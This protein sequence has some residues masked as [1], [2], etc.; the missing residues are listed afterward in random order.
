[1]MQVLVFDTHSATSMY[2][3]YSYIRKTNKTTYAESFKPPREVLQTDVN[4]C[5]ANCDDPTLSKLLIMYTWYKEDAGEITVI[6]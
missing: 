5:T 3:F 1:M 6:G 4:R 2:V